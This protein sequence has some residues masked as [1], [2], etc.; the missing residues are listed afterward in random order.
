M[1]ITSW[2]YDVNKGLWKRVRVPAFVYRTDI[3][4]WMEHDHY[5]LEVLQ[6]KIGRVALKSL[7]AGVKG[8]NKGRLRLE[9]FR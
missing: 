5:K 9:L 8:R 1:I 3:F 6:K 2:H 7:N 4:Y